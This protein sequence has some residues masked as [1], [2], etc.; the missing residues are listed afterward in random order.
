MSAHIPDFQ[1]YQLAF[2]AH[3]RDPVRNPPPAGVA[4]ER[5]AVYDE[6]VFNNLQE[7]V[8]ACFPVASAVLGKRRWRALN[9][10][11]MRDYSANSPLFREIPEQF[12]AFLRQNE[13]PESELPPYLYALCHYEWLELYVSALPLEPEI[14]LPSAHMDLTSHV[15]VF[16]PTMQLLQYDYAVHKISARKKPKHPEQTQL[17]VYRNSQHAVKFVEINAVT[18]K[19]IALIEAQGLSGAQALQLLAQQLAHPQPEVIMQFGLS[20]L[21]EL[22]A[23]EIITGVQ[24]A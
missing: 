18:Y 23:Q 11:F 20:I 12:L 17:I 24:S 8:S 7:S 2:T 3:L 10:A 9:Q 5:M 6:I 1:R 22:E 13:G 4:P 21:H 15:P 16:N 14:H 19:L